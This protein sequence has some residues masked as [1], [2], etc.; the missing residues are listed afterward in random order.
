MRVLKASLEERKIDFGLV[1][2]G[3]VQ[4]GKA[5]KKEPKPPKD[6]A[7]RGKPAK[8]QKKKY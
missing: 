4:G 7:E 3:Q 6:L 1:E 2:E 5:S 8:R